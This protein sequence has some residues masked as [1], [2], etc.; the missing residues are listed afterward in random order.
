LTKSPKGKDVATSDRFTF[1]S[2]FTCNLAR[3]KVMQVAAA[4]VETA[5]EREETDGMVE[6]ERKHQIEVG[7]TRGACA[8]AGAD[9]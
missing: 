5:K 4:R 2:A 6:E 3:I 9:D 7:L 8:G 1:N